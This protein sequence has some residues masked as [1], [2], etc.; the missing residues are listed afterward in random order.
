MDTLK[1]IAN[2]FNVDTKKLIIELN[3]FGRNDLAKLF[4]ELG[5]TKGTEIGVLLGRYSAVLCFYNKNLKL[6]SIDPFQEMK[7]YNDIKTQAQWDEFYKWTKKRIKPYN[8]EL[9]REKSMDALKLF[10]DKS[11]DFVYIDGN[12]AFTSEA[13][14]IHGWGKKV[15]LGGIISGH[16]YIQY[17]YKSC[18]HS[19]EVVNAYIQAYR[20]RPLFIIGK[21][22]DKIRS[23]FWVKTNG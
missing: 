18:S 19:W 1:Y 5:F 12:H 20:I 2:K 17:R 11:L 10:K 9:I 4:Y 22:K 16:D 15:R 14:D 21:N 8:C 23:W 13:N 6:Y 3:D 7:E